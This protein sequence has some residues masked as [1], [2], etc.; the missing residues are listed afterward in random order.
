MRQVIAERWMTIDRMALHTEQ[1]HIV[2]EKRPIEK[3]P[4]V[5]AKLEQKDYLSPTSINRYLRCGLQ[6]YYYDIAGIK[7]P[8]DDSDEIDNRIFGTIFHNASLF[9]YDSITGVDRKTVDEAHPFSAE[10][11]PV[12][13]QQIENVIKSKTQM[14]W[15]VNKAFCQDLFKVEEKESPEYN[16]LQLIH[17]NVIMHYL[18]QLLTID[19]QLA[20]FAIHGLEGKVT[21]TIMAKTSKGMKK[22]SVGGFIDRL[23]EVTGKDGVRRLR[24]LDYKTGSKDLKTLSCMDDV[25]SPEKIKDHSDYYLQAMLYSWIVSK[26]AEVNPQGLPVSPA[27]LF[28]QHSGKED[29][30]PVLKFSQGKGT[31]KKA[32]EINDIRDYNDEMEERLSQLIGEIFEPTHPFKPTEDKT[33]CKNCPYKR[34]CRSIVKK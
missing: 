23:D 34:L 20:P 11:H 28:I 29:Y 9:V 16:G 33:T 24:V 31:S 27:L 13:K 18:K 19:S 32:I 5:L 26:S 25:F 17:R 22:V 4:E 6:F 21:G 3:T 30:S 1:V 7:E 10:G 8:D 2:W 15:A 12:E 14:E